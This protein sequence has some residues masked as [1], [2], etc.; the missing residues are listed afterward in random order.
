[1]S[2]LLIDGDGGRSVGIV[3]S[4]TETMEFGLFYVL[5]DLSDLPV[6]LNTRNIKMSV[7]LK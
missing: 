7:Y 4:R 6:A 2:Y 5:T 3:R 1:M